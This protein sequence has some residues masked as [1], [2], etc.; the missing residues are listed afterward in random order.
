[1]VCVY[2]IIDYKSLINYFYIKLLYDNSQNTLKFNKI[3]KIIKNG[4]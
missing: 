2:F 3:C 4:N 1:M